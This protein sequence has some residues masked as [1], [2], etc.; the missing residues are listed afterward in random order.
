[1]RCLPTY[2]PSLA[3]FC[4]EIENSSSLRCMGVAWRCRLAQSSVGCIGRFGKR[5]PEREV[6][7]GVDGDF[8]HGRMTCVVRPKYLA[9]TH[10][11]SNIRQKVTRL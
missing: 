4:S 9:N 10:S 5:L 8:D 3:S 1:M 11:L 2:P 7:S 6:S